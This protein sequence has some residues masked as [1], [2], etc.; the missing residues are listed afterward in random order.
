MP[1]AIEFIKKGCR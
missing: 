1:I